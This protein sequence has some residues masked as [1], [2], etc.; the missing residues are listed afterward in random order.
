VTK[1]RRSELILVGASLAVTA[2]LARRIRG[3]QPSK[4]P[5]PFSLAS[6]DG[7]KPTLR[8][9]NSGPLVSALQ[10]HLAALAYFVPE[11]TGEFDDDTLHAVTAF[12]KVNGLAPDGI[13]G[14][15]TLAALRHPVLPRPRYGSWK[16]HVE[17]SLG[18]QVVL[19]VEG[20]RI[21]KI[22][23]VSTGSR[24]RYVVDGVP[25]DA[26][27]PSGRWRIL[28]R[29]DGW[30]RSDLQGWRMYRPVYFTKL[31]HA[32]HGLESVPPYPA[33]H[34]CA[35]LTISE[36]DYLYPLV[37]VGTRTYVYED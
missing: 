30:H 2:G 11:M 3:A 18:R 5:P 31:G 19:V 36:M 20:R 33:S 34:G 14:P 29:I 28:W 7:T 13:V 21:V 32:L 16:R 9:G 17:V 22:L 26:A 4:E 15:S 35:R 8:T 24:E 27:T 12:Q 6:E 23:D 1:S 25:K 37:P 10:E